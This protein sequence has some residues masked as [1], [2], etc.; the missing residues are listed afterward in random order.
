MSVKD[1]DKLLSAIGKGR[2]EFEFRRDK[3]IL[4]LLYGA[5]LRISEA[6]S[7]KRKDYPIGEWLRVVGKGQKHR[8]VPILNV[9]KDAI[10]EYMKLVK[11][12]ENPDA[13]I[14]L[15]IRGDVL[16]PRIIQRL[17]KKVRVKLNL[18][19]HLSPH[20]LRHTF[21][22]QLLAGGGDLRSIQDLLGHSSLSSTQR[23]TFVDEAAL[24]EI[25]KNTHP[26]SNIKN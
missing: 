5:G 23:Y 3:A 2:S 19:D 17:M 25:H 20:A 18:P 12:D 16:S 1:V 13:P 7:I 24:L 6:I 14:F 26:R 11:D 9:V 22:T 15:G 8:D 4:L 21:A 10:D